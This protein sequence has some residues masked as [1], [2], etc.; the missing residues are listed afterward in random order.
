MRQG[1]HSYQSH[2]S[3]NF[4]AVLLAGIG[5]YVVYS[6]KESKG[7]PHTQSNH[8]L[9]GATALTGYFM[10]VFGMFLHPF[11]PE[12]YVDYAKMIHRF[13]GYGS[14]L[15]GWIAIIMGFMSLEPSMIMTGLFAAPLVVL[16]CMI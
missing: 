15:I 14:T 8:A 1:G 16:S 10:Q 11:V 12:Q 5:W 4:L 3:M 6:Y 2:A 9:V 13:S 7:M